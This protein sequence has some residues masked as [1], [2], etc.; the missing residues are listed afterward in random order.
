MRSCCMRSAFCD[1]V[2]NGTIGDCPC[3][4]CLVK[5]T[6]IKICDDLNNYYR[7]IFHFDNEEMKCQNLD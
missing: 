6:C 7:S 1:I 5:V 3:L 2:M 4:N